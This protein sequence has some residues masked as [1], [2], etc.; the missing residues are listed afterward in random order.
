[1]RNFKQRSSIENSHD[2][3]FQKRQKQFGQMAI[4]LPGK[5]VKFDKFGPKNA[6][7]GSST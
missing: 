4:F 7:F 3:K 5:P 1:M 6:K 2:D